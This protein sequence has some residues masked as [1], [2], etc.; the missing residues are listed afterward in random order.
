MNSGGG[1]DATM[2]PEIE[3]DQKFAYDLRIDNP[4]DGDVAVAAVT[5]RFFVSMTIFWKRFGGRRHHWE[6]YSFGAKPVIN[7]IFTKYL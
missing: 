5:S 4:Y 1:D 2:R 7:F 6:Y 3:S